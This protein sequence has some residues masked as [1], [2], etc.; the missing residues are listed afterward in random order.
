MKTLELIYEQDV[1][2]NIESSEPSIAISNF[3]KRQT[4]NSKYAHF[5]G[6]WEELIQLIK[7]HF[8][9]KTEAP[10]RKGVWYVA[11]PPNKFFSSIIEVNAGTQLKATFSARREGEAPYIQIE[12]MGV[13][14]PSKYITIVLYSHELLAKGNEQSSD[15]DFEVV[16]INSG[17]PNEPTP[18]MA[19]ARNQLA[20]PGG[21][22]ASYSAQ[23]FANSIIYWSNKAPVS[24]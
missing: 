15:A 10:N 13:K 19:M 20:L 9:N 4:K 24:K 6:S 5:E 12:A 17:S 11:L 16:S 8:N 1:L 23:D 7:D 22:Q 18:P 2:N 14:T 21:T 3:A